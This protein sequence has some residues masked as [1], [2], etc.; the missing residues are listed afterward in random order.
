MYLSN[1]AWFFIVTVNFKSSLTTPTLLT[2]PINNCLALFTDCS[3]S[4]TSP[5]CSYNKPNRFSAVGSLGLRNIY[6]WSPSLAWMVLKWVEL[7]RDSV[8]GER[9][10]SLLEVTKLWHTHWAKPIA[11]SG[12]EGREGGSERKGGEKGRERRK[13]DSQSRKDSKWR[14]IILT[15]YFRSDEIWKKFIA[16][17]DLPIVSATRPSPIQP[18]TWVGSHDWAFSNAECANYY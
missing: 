16:S 5:S 7:L 4:L 10:S 18:T 1:R 12:Y 11:D 3:A 2:P 15:W 8:D 9:I 6:F 17:F 14:I 13:G